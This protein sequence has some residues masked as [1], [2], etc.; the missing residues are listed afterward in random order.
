MSAAALPVPLWAEILVSLLLLASAVFTLAAAIG[1]VRLQSFFQRMHPPALI[2][3]G[4]AWCVTL[5][6]ITYFSAQGHGLVLHVWIIIILL[7]ITVPIATVLLAR[8]ALFRNRQ[9][10]LAGTPLPLQPM[11]EP[12]LAEGESADP[13][14]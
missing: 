6:S 1:L 9:E 11:V 7:S 13:Q 12:S 4:A 5:A 10:R 2:Y 8:A 3:T 14:T